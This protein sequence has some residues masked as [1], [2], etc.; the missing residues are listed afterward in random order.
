MILMLPTRQR[1]VIVTPP[2]AEAVYSYVILLALS[3]S[4]GHGTSDRG[5]RV[6]RWLH[7]VEW[8]CCRVLHLF[9]DERAADVVEVDVLDQ[10]EVELVVGVHVWHDHL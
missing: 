9:H 5:E 4:P 10:A 6:V 7:V 3:R 1:A 8:E 2:F